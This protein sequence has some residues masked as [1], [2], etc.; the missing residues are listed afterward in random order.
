MSREA[1]HA[2]LTRRERDTVPLEAR[3]RCALDIAH[4]LGLSKLSD[5]VFTTLVEQFSID[6]HEGE[7]DFL[8][9][10][11]SRHEISPPKYFLDSV[12]EILFRKLDSLD[13]FDRVLTYTSVLP[14]AL[15]ESERVSLRYEFE[16]TYEQMVDNLCEQESS[17]ETLR[18]YAEQ[19]KELGEK[20]GLDVDREYDLLQERASDIEAEC[21]SDEP[22]DYEGW[23]ESAREVDRTE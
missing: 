15:A 20:F 23:K 1:S 4:E 11:I 18:E 21:E 6:I 2:L 8:L 9:K 17:A 16:S 10:R 19:L 12:K 5:W 22:S 13:D 14:Q 7:L 3:A